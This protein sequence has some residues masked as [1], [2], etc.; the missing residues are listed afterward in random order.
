MVSTRALLNPHIANIVRC[1]GLL[2]H[3]LVSSVWGPSRCSTASIG[4]DIRSC[5]CVTNALISIWS[6]SPKCRDCY[7]S[8]CGFE[9]QLHTQS[10][11]WDEWICGR[12]QRA[13][14]ILMVVG[15][16]AAQISSVILL[17]IISPSRAEW[18]VLHMWFRPWRNS[19][20]STLSKWVVSI[21]VSMQAI[22][23]PIGSRQNL[24]RWK[25]HPERWVWN[26]IWRSKI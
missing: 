6:S 23:G 13:F 4:C 18:S 9:G 17:R 22:C 5:W 2:F 25:F 24:K 3:V 21:K 8:A 16:C 14:I 7:F 1:T 26:I 11:A 12:G 15:Y 10:S 19:I 20:Y